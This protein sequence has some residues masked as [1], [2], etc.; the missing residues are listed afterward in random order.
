MPPPFFLNKA[1]EFLLVHDSGFGYRGTHD[2]DRMFP[3]SLTVRQFSFPFPI[4][5][6]QLHLK[7][8]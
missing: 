2:D 5:L 3:C 1:K 8:H 7:D 4:G 6:V